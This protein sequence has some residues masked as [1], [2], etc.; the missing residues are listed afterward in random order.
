MNC[1]SPVLGLVIVLL[2]LAGPASGK[3]KTGSIP[4]VT[5]RNLDGK[6]IVLKD[7]LTG[8]TVIT[9]WATWCKPCRKELPELQKLVERYGE[10]GFQVVGI[11]GDGPVDQAKIRPYVKALGYD[12]IIIP[13]PDGEIRRRFQVEV[14][15]TSFLVDA[16]GQILHRQVGYRQGDEKVLEERIQ[17]LLGDEMP[18]KDETNDDAKKDATEEDAG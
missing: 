16:E 11:N 3:S 10:R 1:F 2:G 18:G 14:F 8:P 17:D 4:N 7:S 6:K 15:P 12:F 13:D 5:A 9:F